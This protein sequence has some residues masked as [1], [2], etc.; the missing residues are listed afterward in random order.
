MRGLLSNNME[1]T[2]TR[3]INNMIC[4]SSLSVTGKP[5]DA[6][7]IHIFLDLIQEMRDGVAP[8]LT[9]EHRTEGIVNLTTLNR[10]FKGDT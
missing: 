2:A 4:L 10:V 8:R 7:R 1:L 6:T 5:H 9:R 3:V